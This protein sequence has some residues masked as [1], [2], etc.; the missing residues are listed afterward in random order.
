LIDQKEVNKVIMGAHQLCEING[1]IKYFVNTCGSLAI[2]LLSKNYSIK[3]IVI[4]E[5]DKI[6]KY[7]DDKALCEVSRQP[8]ENLTKSV[9]S[10]LSRIR[11]VS[12][13]L[14]IQNYGYDIVPIFDNIILIS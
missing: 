11:S 3:V 9:V 14:K 8:E 6:Q 1:E 2:A 12:S 4:A 5:K 10:E 13:G 7:S